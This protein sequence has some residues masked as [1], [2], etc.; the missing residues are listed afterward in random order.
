MKVI[1]YDVKR[2]LTL[3]A[4]AAAFVF[5]V[6]DAGAKGMKLGQAIKMADGPKTY[7]ANTLTVEQLQNCLAIETELDKLDAE[8][9]SERPSIAKQ[10]AKINVVESEI[11][12]LKILLETDEKPTTQ[13]QVDDINKSVDR[14]N[15]LVADYKK[16][17]E[18]YSILAK[19]YNAKLEKQKN[20]SNN[21]NSQCAQKK[22]YE[23]DMVIAKQQDTASNQD[24]ALSQATNFLHNTTPKAGKAN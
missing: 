4:V 13:E 9:T 18:K 19:D 11:K 1:A 6:S 23:S 20:A 17:A 14:H 3:L 7:D 21:H 15:K 22:Y 10:E 24:S 16:E 12:F 5:P 2:A 8:L